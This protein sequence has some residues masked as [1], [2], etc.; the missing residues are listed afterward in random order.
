MDIASLRQLFDSDL[1]SARAEADLRGVRDKYL[2][3]K[4]GLV[5]AFMKT[6]AAAPAGERAAL[7]QAANEF[8]AHVETSIE[9]RLA[10]ASA[11]RPAGDAIDVTLPGRPP[12]LGHRHPLLASARAD[13][14]HLPPPGLPHRRRPGAGGRLPQL[15]SAQHAGRAPRA[16]H[17]G[18]AVSRRARAGRRAG[19][20]DTAADAHLGHADPL[21]GDAPAA[22]PADRARAASTAATAST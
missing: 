1:A 6:V 9:A 5:S 4:N 8:K 19:R 2:S 10:A 3:R 18:H 14:S 20:R 13:R 15:R 7:G 17:A 22:D 16:R 11:T 21:H 12:L